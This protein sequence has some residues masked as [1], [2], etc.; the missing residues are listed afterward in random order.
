MRVYVLQRGSAPWAALPC[1]GARRHAP[2][3]GVRAAKRHAHAQQRKPV[4]FRTLL[5]SL[6]AERRALISGL[7]D[8][9]NGGR[10][11]ARRWLHLRLP[12]A[13]PGAGD[14]DCRQMA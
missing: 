12:A 3:E 14:R 6:A 9:A 1:I 8:E 13:G 2:W 11:P 7:G 4:T 10:G 5:V